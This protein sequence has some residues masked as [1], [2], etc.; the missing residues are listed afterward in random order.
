MSLSAKL[1]E[2]R[3]LL[4]NGAGRTLSL[5]YVEERRRQRLCLTLSLFCAM[6]VF[7]ATLLVFY[8]HAVKEL[9]AAQ[10]AAARSE[11]ALHDLNQ[12]VGPQ[13]PKGCETTLVLMRHCEK[14][15]PSV[16]D[17]HGTAHCSYIGYERSSYITTLFGSDTR[18]RWPMPSHLF[19]LIPDR[20]T[21]MNYREYETLLPLSRKAEL[22][23]ELVRH[24]NFAADYF[25]LL[26]TGELCGK[27][28][29][30]SWK[31]EYLPELAIHLGCGPE[32]GC[33]QLYD[34]NE[35]DEMWLLKYVFHPPLANHY[36]M[37]NA[38]EESE[39]ANE[40][41]NEE[42]DGVNAKNLDGGQRR[43]QKRHR[44]GKRSPRDK[45][46]VYATKAKQGFDPLAFSK[47]SGDYPEG[48]APQGGAWRKR[49]KGEL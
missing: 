7:V 3:P 11:A 47:Q 37:D 33:P 9:R 14:H 39:E 48:G 32:D 12:N 28:T 35:F 38:E 15:G 49:W 25:N 40:E 46:S 27:I 30:V 6:C 44:N 41:D 18:A 26:Q 31:H 4:D 10:T 17:S 19:A 42:T 45:W 43:L 8:E 13:I 29:V 24:P 21:H 2:A 1:G 36:L 34:E 22:A 23:T 5:D 16:I 20:G